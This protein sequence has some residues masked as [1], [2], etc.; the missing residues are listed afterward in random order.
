MAISDAIAT[1][2]R[3][4]NPFRL[5]FVGA[6]MYVLSSVVLTVALV[7]KMPGIIKLAL[8]LNLLLSFVTMAVA[9]YNNY[10]VVHGH[11]NTLATI[12]GVMIVV[13]GAVSLLS[14]CKVAYDRMTG[15]IF[16][17]VVTKK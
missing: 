10:C 3:E 6:V 15:K 7:P 4:S 8:V 2:L 16:G 14:S 17:S 9:L 5:T 1:D 12:Q 11:C 13:V